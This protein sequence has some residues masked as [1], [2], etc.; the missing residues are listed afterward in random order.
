[1]GYDTCGTGR[2]I[3]FDMVSFTLY[4]IMKRKVEMGLV[5]ELL[6]N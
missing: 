1:M 2:V 3:E 6:E 5:Q 4:Y